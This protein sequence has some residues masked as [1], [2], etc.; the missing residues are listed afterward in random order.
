VNVA[1][2]HIAFANVLKLDDSKL[3]DASFTLGQRQDAKNIF[4]HGVDGPDGK[5]VPDWEDAFKQDIHGAFIIAGDSHGTVNK[6]KKEIE[7]IFG[8]GTKNASIK[9]VTS[10]V[11]DVRPGKV[12]AHEHFG[13]LDGISNPAVIGFDKNPPPGPLPI[14]PK[15]ILLG[16]KGDDTPREPWMANGSFLTFRYL[17]QK[18]PEFNKFLNDNAIQAPG[19]T[20]QEGADLLGA[21]LVGRWKSGAPIDLAPFKD[22]PELA[23]DPQ[24]NNNFHFTAEQSFQK[25]CP[26][27]A[28]IRKTNPRADLESLNVSLAKRRIIRRGI[29]FGP[30]VTEDEKKTQKTALG[31]GL[32]F[33][34]YSASI[35]DGFKFIQSSWV[36]NTQFP[37]NTPA[38][39][40]PGLDPL[41][42]QGPGRTAQDTDDIP[43]NM[44]GTDPNDPDKQ[45]T[46]S[47][48]WVVARGGEYFFSPSVTGLGLIAASA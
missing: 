34:S 30:E 5:F 3:N 6:K 14:D 1:F 15:F 20:Q 36:N 16:Q 35:V 42:G 38:G 4:D 8:E 28:H 11:G 9:E 17:F 39:Q 33:A 31:R 22:D 44:T 26:F 43:P 40:T 41:I 46:L 23:A 21:R 10:I 7:G 24:E 48:E 25:L 12:S 18:V 13:F 29:Q 47:E 37:P 19:L 2:S 27:A 32:L 45:L